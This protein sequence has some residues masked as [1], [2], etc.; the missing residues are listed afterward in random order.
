MA[1]ENGRHPNEKG[2]G[3][4]GALNLVGFSLESA[5]FLRPALRLLGPGKVQVRDPLRNHLRGLVHSREG[6]R[7]EHRQRRNQTIKLGHFLLHLFSNRP[8]IR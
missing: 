2:A 7:G 5:W 6:Q 4:T 3:S 8:S 1:V